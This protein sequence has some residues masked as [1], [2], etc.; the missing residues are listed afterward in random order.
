MG[1]E[2]VT[3][4][5]LLFGIGLIV[6][7]G[8]IRQRGVERRRSS[9]A[10]GIRGRYGTDPGEASFAEIERERVQRER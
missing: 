8:R 7:S 10:R 2:W 1:I 3:V 6:V 9:A 4:G 5:I